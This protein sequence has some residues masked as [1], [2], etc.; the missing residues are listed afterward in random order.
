MN[1]TAAVAA[2]IKYVELSFANSRVYGMFQVVTGIG[3]I[4]VNHWEGN[5]GETVKRLFGDF[6]SKQTEITNF[7]KDL[8]KTDKKFHAFMKVLQNMHFAP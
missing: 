8:M 4:M 2:S 7:Y 6:C 1:R 5:N 3:D